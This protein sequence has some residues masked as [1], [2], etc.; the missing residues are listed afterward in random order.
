MII[1][2]TMN[3]LYT[4]FI[5][6]F[7]SLTITIYISGRQKETNIMEYIISIGAFIIFI[8]LGLIIFLSY[9]YHTI[10]YQNGYHDYPDN[11]TYNTAK[12]IADQ[13]IT[14]TKYTWYC[15]G[16]EAAK[17]DHNKLYNNNKQVT[18]NTTKQEVYKNISRRK[19]VIYD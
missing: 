19:G 13:Y 4:L 6:M 10:P 18:I 5:G 15:K 16:Y 7:I 9:P 2:Y 17:Y 14:T 8:S 3:L 11:S 12:I 1:E